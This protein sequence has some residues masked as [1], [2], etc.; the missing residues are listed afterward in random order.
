MK[1]K[2][3]YLLIGPKGGGKSYIGSLIDRHFN[4]K[5]VR[6]E[7]W[8]KAVKR[9]REIDDQAYVKEVFREIETGIR[10]E[11]LNTDRVVFESTGLSNDFDKMLERLRSDY[12]VR[13]VKINAPDELCL[14]RVRTRDRSIH[15]DVSDD[16]VDRIN[17]Q[18][19]E[20][21]I[22]TDFSIT[23]SNKTDLELIDELKR[24]IK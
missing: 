12:T 24:I 13:S 6:V 16:Q 21:R 22:P 1:Q 5:F 18:V 2:I 3:I 15:V 14:T 19:K 7:D 11:L 17:K 23:N 10:K 4:V 20:K 8:A 9:D